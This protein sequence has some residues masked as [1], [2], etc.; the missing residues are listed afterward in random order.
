MAV[1]P[2][3]CLPRGIGDSDWKHLEARAGLLVA[4]QMYIRAVIAQVKSQIKL[5]LSDSAV[6]TGL[7]RR[8]A[9]QS[10][11]QRGV[12]GSDRNGV[13]Q[14]HLESVGP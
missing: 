4:R 7:L 12:A 10:C 11:A 3:K 8:R 2:E 9:R 5:A 13:S 1:R 6:P 14:P